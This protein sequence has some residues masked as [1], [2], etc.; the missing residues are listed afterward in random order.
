MSN[1]VLNFD[2]LALV[3][4]EILGSEIKIRDPV[5]P[6]RPLAEKNCTRRECFTIFNSIFNSNFLALVVS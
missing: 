5:P 1:S 3:L 4:S 6:V 2:F